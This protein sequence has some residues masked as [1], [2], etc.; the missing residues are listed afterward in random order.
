MATQT[1]TAKALSDAVTKL[2]ERAADESVA[3][4]ADATASAALKLAQAV[5]AMGLQ[6]YVEE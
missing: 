2:A 3:T 1:D 4:N 6:A 5:E